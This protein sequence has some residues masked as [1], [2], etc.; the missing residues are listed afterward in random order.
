MHHVTSVKTPSFKNIEHELSIVCNLKR[1]Y[2]NF[3]SKLICSS[4]LKMSNLMVVMP[5]RDP[6]TTYY[7]DQLHK[8]AVCWT[9]QHVF[10]YGFNFSLIITEIYYDF[11]VYIV[12]SVILILHFL[13]HYFRKTSRTRRTR[14]MLSFYRSKIWAIIP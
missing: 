3:L 2:L 4:K 10:K 1:A 9:L 11:L 8:S 5:N 13:L 12:G 6:E 7:T 14:T